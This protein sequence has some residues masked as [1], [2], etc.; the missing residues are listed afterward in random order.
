VVRRQIEDEIFYVVV[1][2]STQDYLRLGENEHALFDLLDGTRDLVA[3]ASAFESRTGLAI[4]PSDL[5]EFVDS[6]R[7]A[8]IIEASNFDPGVILDEFRRRE[9]T[10]ATSR[11]F[12]SGS[13]ALL[14]L[15]PFDPDRT[16][17]ILA[18]RIRWC[19]TRSFCVLTGLLILAATGVA[20]ASRDRLAPAFAG[21]VDRFF[22]GGA[23]GLAGRMAA[24]YA[25]GGILLVIH[26]AAHGL[27]LKHYGG[28]V[29]EMG[30]A[31]AYFQFPGAYTDTTASYL[32]P[33]RFQRL[34]VS[35]SGGYT[36]LVLAAAATF[37]WWATTP[38]AAA[39]QLA[40][41]VIIFGGPLTLLFN[42]NPL[43]PFDGYYMAVDIFEAPNLLP[44]SFAYLG[45]LL[46]EHVFGVTPL[47]P[48]PPVRLRRVYAI[49]GSLA[50][51]YQ[52]LWTVAV[53]WV[54]FTLISRVA[55]EW[56]GGVLTG[57]LT[58]RLI[59]SRFAVLRRFLQ[60]VWE[61]RGRPLPGWRLSGFGVGAVVFIAVVLTAP[62]L[63]LHV[64]VTGRLSS[65]DRREVRA[66]TPGFVEEI[67]V[68]DGEK[69]VPGQA[70]A[71][72]A[73]PDL[74]A[75]IEGLRWDR[76]VGRSDWLRFAAAG[77]EA[78]AATQRDSWERLGR[79][80]DLLRRREAGLILRATIPGT[81][82]APHLEERQRMYLHEGDLWCEVASLDN[83]R[84]IAEVAE[85]SLAD[86]RE[87]ARVGVTHS[88]Y[89]SYVF[90]GVVSR[91]S[92][93]GG[94]ASDILTAEIIPRPAASGPGTYEVEVDVGSD[95]GRLRPGMSVEAR[96][97]GP[98]MSLVWRA[99]RAARRIL[100]GRVWW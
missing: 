87:G 97:E 12:V 21:A 39:N 63:R 92:R 6:L 58:L 74:H 68:H 49:F 62:L 96:I 61:E 85:L 15:M 91:V 11:R 82:L 78:N 47:S 19:W 2:P 89:P 76:E 50:W 55:G 46:R 32:L 17:A 80:L 14:K 54:V 53:P 8:G 29:P 40:L 52:A 86:V 26:E 25:V 35:F 79:D 69:V 81:L 99:A 20:V 93:Q 3:L 73:D 22:S 65:R 100:W 33:S 44:Q 67:L 60:V 5:A 7:H 72:L 70:L 94:Y 13:L 57:I 34:M 84:V 48:R 42:W 83:L 37:V 66:E 77:D 45:D 59:S 56:I 38:G 10:A 28:T 1:D 23:A 75:R 36:G 24:L 51:S 98:R 64:H 43:V 90:A 95:G 27:T 31:L 88:G 9:R 71:I 18:R 4:A 41:A 16:L 30:L